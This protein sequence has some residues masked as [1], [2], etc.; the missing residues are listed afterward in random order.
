LL[1]LRA[2]GT[3]TS[4]EDFSSRRIDDI[5]LQRTRYFAAANE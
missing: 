2:I 4:G 1:E 5:E 3:G